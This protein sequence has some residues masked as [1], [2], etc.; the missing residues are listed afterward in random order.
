MLGAVVE[1]T[2]SVRQLP[3]QAQK[4]GRS[5]PAT[6]SGGPSVGLRGLRRPARTAATEPPFTGRRTVSQKVGMRACRGRRMPGPAV[7]LRGEVRLR[8]RPGRASPTRCS[9]RPSSCAPDAE[10]TE[11]SATEVVVRERAAGTS[12]TCS[13]TARVESGQLLVRSNCLR[14][15]DVRPSTPLCRREPTSGGCRSAQPTTERLVRRASG[16]SRVGGGLGAEGAVGA[17]QREHQ[18]RPAREL[19]DV[20]DRRQVVVAVPADLRGLGVGASRRRPRC[21]C[22]C[23]G[24]SMSPSSKSSRTFCSAPLERRAARGSPRPSPPP[25][26]APL[27]RRSSSRWTLS[28]SAPAAGH[29]ADADALAEALDQR[30]ARPGGSE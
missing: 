8:H 16:S 7:Q 25:S 14:S 6:R 12:D 20:V 15:L 23:S 2:V 5:R 9:S 29:V 21:R 1:A 13:T 4:A 10:P 18:R 28:S 24:R 19:V 11:W 26:S 17:G 30:R 22:C 3:F 27:T